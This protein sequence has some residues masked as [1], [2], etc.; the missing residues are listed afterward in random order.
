MECDCPTV[1]AHLTNELP[2]PERL[3]SN[4][5]GLLLLLA[6]YEALRRRA[7]ADRLAAVEIVNGGDRGASDE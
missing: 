7:N 2:A 1:P 5:R 4:Q 3:L 6:E